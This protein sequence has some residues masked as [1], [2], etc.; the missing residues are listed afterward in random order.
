MDKDAK[1]SGGV[2]GGGLIAAALLAAGAIFIASKS[3]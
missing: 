1:S 3:L 2:P